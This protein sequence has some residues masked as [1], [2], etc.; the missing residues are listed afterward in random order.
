M[1]FP[2]RTQYR[3]QCNDAGRRFIPVHAWHSNGDLSLSLSLP[4]SV[5]PLGPLAGGFPLLFQVIR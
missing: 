5:S 4:F 3:L 1:N 2:R